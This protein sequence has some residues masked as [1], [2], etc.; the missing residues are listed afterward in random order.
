MKV[1]MAPKQVPS[2]GWNGDLVLRHSVAVSNRVTGCP[3]ALFLVAWA[4]VYWG[5]IGIMENKMEAAIVYWGYIG[6]MEN[7]MDTTIVYSE[8]PCFWAWLKADR[9]SRD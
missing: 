4:V 2:P 1:E 3:C 9:V 8:S 7:K 5:Y 6:I